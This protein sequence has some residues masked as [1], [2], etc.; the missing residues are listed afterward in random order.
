MSKQ[1]SQR[2]AHQ[3]RRLAQKYKDELNERL[4]KWNDE[5]P[6]WEKIATVTFSN[7]NDPSLTSVRIARQL[8]HA[9]V[10]VPDDNCHLKLFAYRVKENV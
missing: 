7:N 2:E 5:Y 6:S 8:G 4:D 10:G 1:I 3:W 9:V